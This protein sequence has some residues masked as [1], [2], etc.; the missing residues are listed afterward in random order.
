MKMYLIILTIFFSCVLKTSF[1][2]SQGTFIK[3]PVDLN[4]QGAC[5]LFAADINNDGKQDILGTASGSNQV[6]W[7]ENDGSVPP[8]FIFH[9]IDETFT[10]AMNVCSDDFNG[11]SL[12]DVVGA[13]WYGNQIALWTNAGG[14]PTA[15]TKQFIDTAFTQAHEVK[16]ANIDG[17]GGMDIVAASAGKNEVSWWQNNGGGPGSWIKF[18][19][20]SN[21]YGARSVFPVDID[22]D[23]DYDIVCAAFTSNDI[24]LFR[25]NGGNPVQW[26][27]EIIDANFNGAHWVYACDMDNDNDMDVLGAGY[28]AGDIAIWYN[29]GGNPIQWAKFTLESNLPGALSVIA[30]DLNQDNLPD[31]IAAGDQAGDVITWYNQGGLVPDFTK[32]ILESSLPGAWP[33]CTFDPDAD[34]DRDILAASSSLNDIFW[35]D[36]QLIINSMN[37]PFST[38]D[39]SCTLNCFPIP[40]SEKTEIS[41]YLPEANSVSLQVVTLSGAMIRVLFEGTAGKGRNVI[42]WD[43]KNASDDPVKKGFY[44]CIFQVEGGRI[45]SKKVI[46]Q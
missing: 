37:E 30:D 38:D 11:D 15:W 3:R 35:W 20:S 34:S 14:T 5:S 42:T 33:V 39:F 2:F 26:S 32:M 10:G 24:L 17:T 25:N 13:A 22:N 23:G 28:M 31:V 1:V 12:M 36:N 41:F 4:F 43:G 27:Q 29:N 19:V 45:I 7:W 21:V 6:A 44:I 40:F 16:A 8:Q 18:I 46:K 9:L